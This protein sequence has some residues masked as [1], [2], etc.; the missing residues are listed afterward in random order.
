MW[1]PGRRA[2]SL[3]LDPHDGRGKAAERERGNAPSTPL[4]CGVLDLKPISGP[5]ALQGPF[6]GRADEPV[7]QHA[8]GQEPADELQDG[9]VAGLEA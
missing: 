4:K 5:D 2:A 7:R 6:V 9:L 8:A 1:A 3:A